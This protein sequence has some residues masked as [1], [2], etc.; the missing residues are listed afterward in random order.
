MVIIKR[1]KALFRNISVLMVQFRNFQMREKPCVYTG[2]SQTLFNCATKSIVFWY[3]SPDATALETWCR[4]NMKPLS[5]KQHRIQQCRWQILFRH[6]NEAIH[7]C[8]YVFQHNRAIHYG[9]PMWRMTS[10]WKLFVKNPSIH[11]R[12]HEIKGD[13]Q[14]WSDN[15]AF[16]SGQ[17]N[18]T[19]GCNV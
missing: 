19:A 5:Q 15:C 8:V 18:I 7:L 17:G 3:L 11:L 6:T 9:G 13:W 14:P 12:L 2:F 1:R 4:M 10:S 16:S